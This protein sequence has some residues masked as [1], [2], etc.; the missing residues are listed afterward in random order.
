MISEYGGH[1]RFWFTLNGEKIDRPAVSFHNTGGFVINPDD[2][3]RL[4]NLIILYLNRRL[5]Q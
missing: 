5:K 1:E 2:T 4:K 3:E